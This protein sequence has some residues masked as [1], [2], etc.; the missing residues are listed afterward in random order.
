MSLICVGVQAEATLMTTERTSFIFRF[1]AISA[2]GFGAKTS[3]VSVNVSD[4][5]SVKLSEI[6]LHDK[7]PDCFIGHS[8]DHQGAEPKPPYV[9]ILSGPRDKIY[10]GRIAFV[11][12]STV[13][14]SLLF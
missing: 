9:T 1:D 12:S 5:E 3:N 10:P 2:A 13:L 11:N 7:L 14:T 8:Q 4:G 6:V